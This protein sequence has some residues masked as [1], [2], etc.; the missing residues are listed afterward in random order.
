MNA[1]QPAGDT[2]LTSGGQLPPLAKL[3]NQ[4]ALTLC[5]G[6]ESNWPTRCF[7]S[8][9]PPLD[10]ATGI[11]F[12]QNATNS[13]RSDCY[14]AATKQLR[15]SQVQALTLCGNLMA[16]NPP[17]ITIAENAFGMI[18]M[19]YADIF[20]DR[21]EAPN[22]DI[23][24]SQIKQV[25][26]SKVVDKRRQLA[27]QFVAEE[28]IIQYRM[29]LVGH[30]LMLNQLEMSILTNLNWL[31][32][33]MKTWSF[34]TDDVVLNDLITALPLFNDKLTNPLLTIND[35]FQDYINPEILALTFADNLWDTL[36]NKEYL[37]RLLTLEGANT[38]Y[39][40]VRQTL[41]LATISESQQ[42]DNNDA[43]QSLIFSNLLHVQQ[44]NYD[45]LATGVQQDE[46][47]LNNGLNRVTLAA[48]LNDLLNKINSVL[49]EKRRK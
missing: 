10:V 47:T 12:C 38:I 25:M 31:M 5:N 20:Y 4:Q 42:N 36:Q 9:V 2:Y 43:T 3:T 16:P 39:G 26:S 23:A 35:Q 32:T 34:D 24:L 19:L 13:S 48:A 27:D 8:V 45:T 6:T 44:V 41:K 46:D 7:Y 17:S 18:N 49:N 1:L 28:D 22:I 40:N 29:E 21:P 14:F 30:T 11:T 15:L 37:S 33:L